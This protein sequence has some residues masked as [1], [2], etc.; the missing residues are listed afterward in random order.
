M[1]ECVGV[2]G[3]EGV[4]LPNSNDAIYGLPLPLH[5]HTQ[6]PADI[7]GQGVVGLDSL[8]SLTATVLHSDYS[9]GTL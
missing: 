4:N 9:E 2:C 8:S 3:V 5:T 1:S 6:Y 7:V